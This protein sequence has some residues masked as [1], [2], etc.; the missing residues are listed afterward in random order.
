MAKLLFGK[1][2]KQA[3]NNQRR[4]KNRA[5]PGEC[6]KRAIVDAFAKLDP[7]WMNT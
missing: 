2:R 1:N 4:I 7:R 6:T 5:L 3:T